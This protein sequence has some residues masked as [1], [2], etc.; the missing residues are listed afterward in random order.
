M[1]R[2]LFARRLLFAALGVLVVILALGAG[3]IPFL[4]QADLAPYLARKGRYIAALPDP[5]S[6]PI[7]QRS[8]AMFDAL[9]TRD[10]KLFGKME[11]VKL[12]V[13]GIV[14]E[15]T[16]D[17]VLVCRNLH[18]FM[19]GHGGPSRIEPLASAL[20]H[21]LKRGGVLVIE[22]HRAD[23][24]KPEK[25]DSGYVRE[26]HIIDIMQ[27]TGFSLV[28]KSE[29]LANP[30]DTHDHPAGVFSLPPVMIGADRKPLPEAE[31]AKYL[32][33]GESDR[34]LL[35]FKKP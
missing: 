5:Q 11:N 1:S 32:A 4:V 31:K 13:N 6:S 18:D 24:T 3:G 10:A 19:G 30:K 33:I 20:Y 16:A 15:G 17:I 25:V 9:R 34:F 21:A 28:A 27:K 22:D 26:D 12:D 29:L 8:I 2:R 23:P 35:K 14:P 7:A